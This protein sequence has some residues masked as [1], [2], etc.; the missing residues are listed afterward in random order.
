MANVMLSLLHKLG[1][2]DLS[3]FGDST[4]ELSLSV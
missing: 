3:R 1:H 2:D 4:G